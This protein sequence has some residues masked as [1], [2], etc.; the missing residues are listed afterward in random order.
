MTSL[1]ELLTPTEIDF[2][3]E[4]RLTDEAASN[5]LLVRGHI[6][7]VLRYHQ[8]RISLYSRHVLASR[9]LD[10][11][12]IPHH[13]YDHLLLAF[14]NSQFSLVEYRR[15]LREFSTVSL[16]CFARDAQNDRLL[17]RSDYQDGPLLAED[18]AGRFAVVRVGDSQ[19]AFI[20]LQADSRWRAS[21][22]VSF[23][24]I[25]ER[26]RNVRQVSFVPGYLETTLAILYEPAKNWPLRVAMTKDTVAL[27]IS[28][29]DL[30]REEPTF[31]RIASYEGLPSDV[32]RMW[33]TGARSPAKGILLPGANEI[34]HVDP[35][36]PAV[37]SLALNAFATRTTKLPGLRKTHG[38]PLQ[39]TMS[40]AVLFDIDDKIF[41]SADGGE[42][43]YCQVQRDGSG[44]R[45]E[46]LA[47]K[48]LLSDLRIRLACRFANKLL[49]ALPSNGDAL[50]IAGFFADLNPLAKMNSI[51]IHDEV[52][53]DDIY[54]ETASSLPVA[55]PSTATMAASGD[56]LDVIGRIGCLGTISDFCIGAESSGRL[57]LATSGGDGYC[58]QVTLLRRDLDLIAEP[59][60]Q[61]ANC[62]AVFP[63]PDALYLVS[64]DSTSMAFSSSSN[65]Q[66]ASAAIIDDQRTVYAGATAIGLIQVTETTIRLLTDDLN[67]VISDLQLEG[68]SRILRVECEGEYLVI[69]YEDR[70]LSLYRL[71]GPDQIER[72]ALSATFPV[73][74]WDVFT[75]DAKVFLVVVEPSGTLSLFDLH[76]QTRTFTNF[77]FSMLPV[78]VTPASSLEGQ[79]NASLL[80][81]EIHAVRMLVDSSVGLVLVVASEV[82]GLS[83]YRSEDLQ[84][85]LKLSGSE[86]CTS[87]GTA[88][89]GDVRAL[90]KVW[91]GD[92]ERP[93][94]LA[95]GEERSWLVLNDALGYPRV[96]GCRLPPR[97]LSI[98][99]RPLG[100][101]ESNGAFSVMR[102]DAR[103]RLDYDWP[104]QRCLIVDEGVRSIV[105]HSPSSTYALL[106]AQ[107]KFF[108]LPKDE[109][110]AI[111]DNDVEA[112]AGAPR[113]EQ[114]VYKVKLLSTRSG[115]IIDEYPLGEDE[116][117][118]C[119]ASA[120]LETKQTSSGRQPF[121]VVGTSMNR[122]EDR[123][124]RGRVLVFDVI[125]VVPEVDRP[126]TDRKFKLLTDAEMKGPVT[127]LCHLNGGLL[128]GLASKV[129]VHS[130]E[131]NEA[132]TGVAFVDVGVYTSCMASVKNFFVVGDIS[133]SLFFNAYQERPPKVVSLGRDYE[134]RGIIQTNFVVDGHS[135]TVTLLGAD[136]LGNVH[137]YEYAPTSA[138]SEGGQRLV[139]RGSLR[140]CDQVVRLRR[141]VLGKHQGCLVAGRGG[142][143]TLLG[144]L[145]EQSMRKCT[146]LQLRLAALL[147]HPAGMHPRSAK[148]AFLV[149]DRP[150]RMARNVVDG[151]RGGLLRM[152]ELPVPAR[153]H[154]ARIMNV[155]NQA[156]LFQLLHRALGPLLRP[157]EQ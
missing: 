98:A 84:A 75:W 11:R 81:N 153:E 22:V 138:E 54:A 12:R 67:M 30:S 116:Y 39:I 29:V 140:L 18:E 96:H 27:L 91:F 57:E 71:G 73:V 86:Y 147:P 133:K 105:Y 121:I 156:G 100:V 65:T 124:A 108:E 58:G 28:T 80:T 36:H 21:T 125:Q 129:I 123:P 82:G 155:T 154:L 102:I 15:E 136:L 89:G 44:R 1:V 76:S 112:P 47:A 139:F 63:L 111:S 68:Y 117:G 32:R 104:Y 146:T 55:V 145:D 87:L 135:G 134:E 3:L 46:L 38:P 62:K 103:L 33:M 17:A 90:E 95:L 40:K 94:V 26:I 101:Y 24:R 31:T 41:I 118:L 78:L 52:M 9:I 106:T 107:R 126:E 70:R 49:F 66:L 132:L 34:I 43:F 79:A 93:V 56:K 61:I 5:L 2:G 8:G 77:L 19:L 42:T 53:D 6:L 83:I 64:T 25:D 74:A 51:R 122:G 110:A 13:P 99:T 45:L 152:A 97:L 143:F 85:F 137:F 20:S 127:A 50:I 157:F 48:T 23:A 14:G 69:Y 148:Q 92:D 16:H 60:F 37:A 72:L 119:L 109:Y 10:I 4:A 149:A 128:V 59:V 7:E 115:S 114:Y 141:M 151:G 35:G 142:S 144:P 150:L 120:T 113:P 88:N 130:F 131:N